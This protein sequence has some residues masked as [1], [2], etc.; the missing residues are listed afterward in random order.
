MRWLGFGATGVRGARQVPRHLCCCCRRRALPTGLPWSCSFRRTHLAIRAMQRSG[1]PSRHT[2]AHQ[3]RSPQRQ[4]PPTWPC[5]RWPP[6]A[7]LWSLPCPALQEGGGAGCG[8]RHRPAPVPAAE[9][10][11]PGDGAVTV[12]YRQRG[13]C[14][15]RPVALQHPHPG[16]PQAGRGAGTPTQL[17][18]RRLVH[19]PQPPTCDVLRDK[20][21]S[22]LQLRLLTA[23][24]LEHKHS[25]CWHS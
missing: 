24:Q 3:V 14:G 18:R 8:R 23:P 6:A 11:S 2:L 9:D 16:K 21:S 17:M 15:G 19:G 10:E 5:S 20:C 12:R 13:G 1:C 7:T 22:R 4:Q 25:L